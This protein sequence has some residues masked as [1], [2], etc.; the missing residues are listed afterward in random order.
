MD[1]VF[2]YITWLWIFSWGL[3]VAQSP[4]PL[5]AVLIVGYQEDRTDEAIQRM[6]SIEAFLKSQNFKVH[7]FYHPNYDWQAICKVSKDCHILV[8]AGHGTPQSNGYGGFTLKEHISPEQIEKELKLRTGAIVC[9]QS[10]C[11]GAGSSAIDDEDIGIQEAERRVRSTAEPFFKI[12]S[13]DYFANNYQDGCLDFLKLIFKN[14]TFG[15]AFYQTATEWA[16]IELEK[17]LPNYP[18]FI[19]IAAS[20]PSGTKILTS[21]DENGKVIKKEEI[22]DFKEYDVAFVGDKSLT[23]RLWR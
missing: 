20:L 6:K 2:R 10:V 17:N 3:V 19:R 5:E 21:Y 11:G 18:P 16:Q 14:K 22:K 1:K 9:F 4:K 13:K 12:G 15:D 23:I 8:Y 7:T